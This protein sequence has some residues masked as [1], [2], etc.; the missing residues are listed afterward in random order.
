VYR[1][2]IA[3]ICIIESLIL[4]R[5]EVTDKQQTFTSVTKIWYRTPLNRVPK[6]VKQGA[7]L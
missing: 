2:V 5:T 7:I 1:Y 3:F 6:H 4:S